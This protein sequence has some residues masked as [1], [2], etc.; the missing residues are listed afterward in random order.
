MPT[1]PWKESLLV[2]YSNALLAIYSEVVRSGLCHV[3]LRRVG[4]VREPPLP[5]YS[6]RLDC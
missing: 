2:S 4:A 6:I 1:F 3:D 5:N